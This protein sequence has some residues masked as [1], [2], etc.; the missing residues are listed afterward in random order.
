MSLAF[1][2]SRDS[3]ITMKESDTAVKQTSA[4]K[5]PGRDG[6]TSHF[7]W[8]FWEVIKELLFNTINQCVDNN[9]WTSTMKQGRVTL[10]AEPG[11]DKSYVENLRAITW[12]NVHL[13]I[14]LQMGW[15][16]IQDR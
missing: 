9:H 7:D 8:F 1:K 16:W 6:S 13:R 2:E 14:L 4:N 10:L 5:A 11:E 15:K 12:L 3:E